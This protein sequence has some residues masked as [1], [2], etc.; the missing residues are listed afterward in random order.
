MKAKTKS[1]STR[2]AVKT[3]IPEGDLKYV[4][5]IRGFMISC[6]KIN[7]TNEQAYR[8]VL[9]E[10]QRSAAKDI[11]TAAE[12][13]KEQEARQIEI[14]EEALE[15][16]HSALGKLAQ[17]RDTARAIE[18]DQ[19]NANY[20]DH[21]TLARFA[22]MAIVEGGTELEQALCDLG[23]IPE[24]TLCG[25]FGDNLKRQGADPAAIEKAQEAAH[26]G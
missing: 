4:A 20:F 15:A 10:R 17:A 14:R 18:T 13:A 24:E 3:S 16:L 9:K 21:Q 5:Q 1:T 26:H 8:H 7:A 23:L 25:Y 11:E 12:L 22:R 19:E 6:G 2:T